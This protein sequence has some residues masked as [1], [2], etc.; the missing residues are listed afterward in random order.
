MGLFGK[1]KDWN[2]V[3]VLFESKGQYTV[4]GN[5]A[6][7]SAAEAIRDGAK[8]HDRAVFW[9]AFDQK[10][11]FLEGAPGAGANLAPQDVLSKLIREL[12]KIKTV[13]EVLATLEAGKKDKIAKTLVWKDV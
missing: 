7:G 9:A 2:V 4:N 10:R 12:P 8:R 6:K 5:R 11:D 3:A 1:K 13:Q